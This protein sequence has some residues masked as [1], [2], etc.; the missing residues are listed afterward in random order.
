M[1]RSTFSAASATAGQGRPMSTSRH[2]PRALALP[3]L[4]LGAATGCAGGTPSAAGPTGV[5][6][7]TV[8]PAVPTAPP[9]ASF[10]R[11]I[12]NPWMPW[13]VGTV[14]RFTGRTADGTEHT[15]VTVTPRTRVVD[16]VTTTVVHDVVR[17]DGTL[18]EDT[19]DWYAQDRSGN[20]WYFGEDTKEYDGGTVD[21]SGSWQAGVD[22]ASAG[23]AMPAHPT[24][25]QSYRQ[26]YLAGQAE[27]QG[28]VLATDAT[29][30]VAY[31][32]FSG[33]VETRD[34]TRLEPTADEHKFYAK[35]IG[36]VLEDSLHQEDRTELVAMTGPRG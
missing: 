14:W 2:R 9:P 31:G 25:G 17:L 28:R 19:D 5:E 1:S 15:V 23:I 32:A 13:K 3:L 7:S 35:G 36:V 6:S 22:G 18:L 34:F 12:D 27:D 26:E 10:V 16:G 30:R 24:V 29:A 8:S 4:L 11:V 33:L 21:T 20:V